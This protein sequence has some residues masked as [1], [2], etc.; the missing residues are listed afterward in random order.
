MRIHRQ[1]GFTLIEL[2]IGVVVGLLVVAAAMAMYITS[3]RASADALRVMK[4]NQE[5]RTIIAMMVDEM[6]RAGYWSSATVGSTD[7]GIPINP[8]MSRAPADV[9]DI[10]VSANLQCVTFSYDATHQSVTP[11]TI[12]ATDVFGFR[13]VGTAVQI[14]DHS[15]PTAATCNSGPWITLNDEAAV[16]ITRLEFS[17]VG[18]KCINMSS[19]GQLL[20]EVTD[21]NAVTPACECDD[22]NI[23]EDYDASLLSG[24][25]VLIEMRQIEI[26]LDAAHVDDDRI[27]ISLREQ[28]KVRNNRVFVFEP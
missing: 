23:C 3:L 11:G 9:T 16:W 1:N 20:W 17:T 13:R 8:F 21:V 24:G 14:P 10:Q 22:D 19:N 5:A 25:D 15:Q 7:D 26:R 4:V 6:R 18:S 2:M 28:V 12:E 27:V